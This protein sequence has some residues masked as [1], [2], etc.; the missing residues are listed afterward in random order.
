MAFR[1]NKTPVLQT[2]SASGAVATFNTALAMPLASCNIA[3][4]AWQEGSGDPSPSNVRA[5]HGFSEVNATRAGKNLFDK[6][7]YQTRKYIDDTTGAI[8]NISNDSAGI[9]DYIPVKAG[10]VLFI[11]A[12]GTVRNSLFDRNKNLI[13]YFPVTGSKA[14]T[15]PDD[16][17]IVLG[18]YNMDI[19]TYQL[20]VG[21][22]RTAYEPYVTPD[23][24]TMQFGQEVYGAEVDAVNGVAHVTHNISYLKDFT[25]YLEDQGTNYKIV[26]T[27]YLLPLVSNVSSVISN[28]FSY[29]IPTRNVGR[30]AQ[31]GN[32]FFYFVIPPD[33]PSTNVGIKSYMES[34]NA[35]VV[36]EAEP[37]DIQLTPTQIE[38]LIGNNTIFADTGDV[39][40]VFKDLD[41]A[42]R[43]NFREV[44]KLPS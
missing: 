40:L 11:P 38:T 16:G 35:Y 13:R 1:T 5:I 24:Y 29:N 37:F 2:K 18:G 10:E 20:E 9:S 17:Y 43:G 42:K 22:T 14:V 3:V 19:D 34:I 23:I 25:Y 28:T 36:Y 4:N 26:R 32:R 41:I 15:I 12:K 21:S 8:I 31:V 39:D 7:K 30:M 44:F 33:I 27:E 6:T